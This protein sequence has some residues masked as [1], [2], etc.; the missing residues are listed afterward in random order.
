VIKDRKKKKKQESVGLWRRYSEKI[1]W[2]L[3]VI[4]TFSVRVTVLC[5]GY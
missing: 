2:N 5:I 1:T 4:G 3:E